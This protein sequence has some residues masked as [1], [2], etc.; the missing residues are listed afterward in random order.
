VDYFFNDCQKY[1]FNK[2]EFVIWQTIFFMVSKGYR[3][4]NIG[5]TSWRGVDFF[6]VLDVCWLG[7]VRNHWVY[8]MLIKFNHC[9]GG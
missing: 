6:K 7:I 8:L 1:I 5:L 9:R 4:E 2:A 3:I